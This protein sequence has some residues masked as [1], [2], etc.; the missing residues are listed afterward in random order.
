MHQRFLGKMVTAQMKVSMYPFSHLQRTKKGFLDSIIISRVLE[1]FIRYVTALERLIFLYYSIIDLQCIRFVIWL[2]F[3]FIMYG[4]PAIVYDL[5]ILNN[6]LGI[7]ET[8]FTFSDFLLLQVLVE[9]LIQL[10]L[11]SSRTLLYGCMNL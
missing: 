2:N 3:S 5:N 1:E 4:L 8:Y 7:E 9:R 11:K 6:V 10:S